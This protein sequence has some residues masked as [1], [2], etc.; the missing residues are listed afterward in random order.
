MMVPLRLH[1]FSHRNDYWIHDDSYFITKFDPGWFLHPGWFSYYITNLDPWWYSLH[2]KSWCITSKITS[3]IS[4]RDDCCVHDSNFIT[5]FYPS[6]WSAQ[7]LRYDEIPLA[8][9]SNSDKGALN[10]QFFLW[11][12]IK[13]YKSF[14]ISCGH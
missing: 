8:G 13:F 9:N 6:R 4:K 3:Q 11:K 5:K 14:L 2:H 1:D 7:L 12:I 10:F